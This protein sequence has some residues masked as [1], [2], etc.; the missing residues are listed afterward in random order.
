MSK[1][2]NAKV[3]GDNVNM[4]AYKG[5]G[6]KRGEAAYRISQSSLKDIADC[7][8][9]WRAGVK[10]EVTPN[11]EWGSLVDAL[12]LTPGTVMER[13][14]VSSQFYQD[15]KGGQKPWN[16]NADTCKEWREDQTRLGK[17][18]VKH[19][20][21][22]QVQ[23]AVARLND[24]ARLAELITCS[25]KQVMVVADYQ[26]DQG[27]IVP[28]SGLLDI[29]PFKDSTYARSLADLKCYKSAK[30]VEWSRQ[31]FYGGLHVQAAFYLDL[32]NAATGEER[33]IFRHIVQEQ[34]EPYETG[35]RMLGE[36]FVK[37]GRGLY[38][39][40]LETYAHCVEINDWPRYDDMV[41]DT[42][43]GWTLTS[44][45]AW[46]VMKSGVNIGNGDDILKD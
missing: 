16:W 39:R 43:E 30:P 8:H 29:V 46:M 36:E 11:M 10:R 37:M 28:V 26:T 42:L 9:K 25:Q 44:A 20:T 17:I 27:M 22:E 45:E 24:D 6:H 19:D 23:L 18:V 34:D 15:K 13:V 38:Q 7:P 3:L 40:A 4:V 14:A 32:Y 12:A 1:F 2:L 33:N 35:R 21:W 31:V 5:A 41:D